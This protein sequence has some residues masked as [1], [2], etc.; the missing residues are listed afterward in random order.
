MSSTKASS[1]PSTPCT[2]HRLMHTLHSFAHVLRHMRRNNYNACTGSFLVLQLQLRM[3]PR[4]LRLLKGSQP[5]QQKSPPICG[6]HMDKAPWLREHDTCNL[7]GHKARIRTVTH[8]P[9]QT[10]IQRELTPMECTFLC[11]TGRHGSH[12]AAARS[13]DTVYPLFRLT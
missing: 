10:P 4:H 12:L 13:M 3:S 7:V 5:V 11:L 8:L 2:S 6:A 1:N 9:H